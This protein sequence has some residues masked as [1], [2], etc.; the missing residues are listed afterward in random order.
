[1]S[2]LR[3][4]IVGQS[5]LQAG[6]VHPHGTAATPMVMPLAA[7]TYDGHT[8]SYQDLHPLWASDGSPYAGVVP[9]SWGKVVPTG[10]P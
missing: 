8:V 9:G 10:R 2:I 7:V 6:P 5:N 3:N 1:M 4:R